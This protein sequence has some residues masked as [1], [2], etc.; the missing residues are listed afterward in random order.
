[1]RLLQVIVEVEHLFGIEIPDDVTFRVGTIGEFEDLVAE[2]CHE[3]SQ[4]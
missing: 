4:S 3:D 1:M 2:L